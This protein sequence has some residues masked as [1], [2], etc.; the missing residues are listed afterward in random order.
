MARIFLSLGRMSTVKIRAGS[1][2]RTPCSRIGAAGAG[3]EERNDDQKGCQTIGSS[4]TQAGRGF[5]QISTALHTPAQL[6]H[7]ELAF[8]TC[9]KTASGCRVRE[10]NS[11]K[12]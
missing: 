10:Y 6:V 2:F 9:G 1:L 4:K 12:D 11:G 3:F 7:R 8:R 5:P